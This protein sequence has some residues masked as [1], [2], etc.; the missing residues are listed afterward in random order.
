MRITLNGETRDV[1]PGTTL[2]QL[3]GLAG[4]HGRRYAVEVNGEICPRA[5]HA[6]TAVAPGDRVEV[7]QAIGGG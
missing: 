7:V 6:D 4:I 1:A 5:E 2:E 3:V